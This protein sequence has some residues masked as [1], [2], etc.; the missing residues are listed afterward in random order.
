MSAENK[1]ANRS[2]EEEDK[3]EQGRDYPGY[4]PTENDHACDDTINSFQR[5][6]LTFSTQGLGFISVPML[7][8][9]MLE[10]GLNTDVIWRVLLGVG[11]LPGLLVLYLRLR[12][13]NVRGCRRNGTETVVASR[14]EPV[15][16]IDSVSRTS[17]IIRTESFELTTPNQRGEDEFNA[18]STLFCDVTSSESEEALVENSYLEDD[19]KHLEEQLDNQDD[20]CKSDVS[21]SPIRGHSRSL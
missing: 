21:T 12:A 3:K 13:G 20:A 16:D 7:A 18:E 10:L 2:H 14:D 17:A 1:E 4:A 9:P 8:Y 11:A 15:G 6:A 5:I 19:V